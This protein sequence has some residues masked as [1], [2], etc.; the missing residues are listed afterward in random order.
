MGKGLIKSHIADGQYLIELVYDTT[1][2]V[3]RVAVLTTKITNIQAFIEE[4]EAIVD[5]PESTSKEVEQAETRLNVAKIKLISAQKQKEYLEDTN[6]V[7]ASVEI[8]AWCADLTTDLTGDIGTVEIGRERE[9]G[10]NVQPGYDSNAVYDEERDGQL[11]PL[12]AQ[13]PEA[14]FFNLAILPG[15]QKWKPTYLYGTLSTIDRANNTGTVNLDATTSSQQALDILQEISVV[16]EFEYMNCHH[17]AFIVSDRVII[18]FADNDFSNPKIIG[19][20]ERPFSCARV[21]LAIR[22]DTEYILWNPVTNALYD[23]AGVDQPLTEAEL[24]VYLTE[25]DFSLE[26]GLSHDAVSDS[27]MNNIYWGGGYPTVD[28]YLGDHYLGDTG[29]IITVSEALEIT[30]TFK[31]PDYEYT[32]AHTV[33]NKLIS[34]LSGVTLRDENSDE[35]K[36]VACYTFTGEITG[37]WTQYPGDLVEATH[38]KTKAFD[39]VSTISGSKITT[40]TEIEKNKTHVFSNLAAPASYFCD[41]YCLQEMWGEDEPNPPGPDIEDYVTYQRF[42]AS[43]GSNVWDGLDVRINDEP[44]KYHVHE[45]YAVILEQPILSTCAD[46][47]TIFGISKVYISVSSTMEDEDY[48]HFW[49][50][51]EETNME[52]LYSYFSKTFLQDITDNGVDGGLEINIYSRG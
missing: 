11:V 12:M 45:Q 4:Q 41:D 42:Q 7:P 34:P 10:V 32:F 52:L 9:N 5:N 47:P 2:V 38:T 22:L 17:E 43:L 13:I 16:A 20:E 23:I 44:V 46:T 28:S 35:E 30:Q 33:S 51:V 21:I 50:G 48:I 37:E 36:R 1:A 19:F 27:M 14:N 49:S 39:Y 18:G 8:N 29:E 40:D 15:A 3:E 26:S 24:N 25:F 31:N 6:F